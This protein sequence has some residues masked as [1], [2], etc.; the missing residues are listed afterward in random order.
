MSDYPIFYG[1]N[2]VNENSLI[3]VSS[4]AA[5][6]YRLYDR[7]YSTVWKTSGQTSGSSAATEEILFQEN[8]VAALKTLDTVILQ[9]C[10]AVTAVL[11]FKLSG[12]W[13]GAITLTS[14]N[15][16]GISLKAAFTAKQAYGLRITFSSTQT[17]NQEKQI[18]EVWA[19]RTL[20]APQKGFYSYEPA[21][22]PIT[23]STDTLDGGVKTALVKWSGDRVTRW[24]ANLAFAGLS[25]AEADTL[26]AVCALGGFVLYPEP[27]TLPQAIYEVSASGD[28]VSCGYISKV[29]S[30]GLSVGFKAEEA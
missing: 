13:G 22:T 3:T 1:P 15:R 21:F 2:A 17:A 12:G 25:Q 29:K 10:N 26:L 16:A 4:G 7:D 24:S 28:S 23:I 14:A 6:A 8:G 30:G 9:N 19:L 11:E 18:G 27:D 20:F 5:V